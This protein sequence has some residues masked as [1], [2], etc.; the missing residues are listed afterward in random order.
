MFV[1]K[2]EVNVICMY[3]FKNLN[4]TN[5]CKLD[6]VCLKFKIIQYCQ[7]YRSNAWLLLNK[8]QNI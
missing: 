2:F 7:K 4:T 5:V 6:Y 3:D 8:I 1:K